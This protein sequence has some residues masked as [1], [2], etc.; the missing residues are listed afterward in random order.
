MRSTPVATVLAA[1]F[2]CTGALAQQAQLPAASSSAPGAQAGSERTPAFD[3]MSTQDRDAARRK[4]IA[5]PTREECRRMR[6]EQIKAA[7][8]ARGRGVK[9]LP[10]PR[11]EACD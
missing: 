3:M 2:V 8:G 5:A 7:A 4:T 6:D 1:C 9:D 10:D 11:Y